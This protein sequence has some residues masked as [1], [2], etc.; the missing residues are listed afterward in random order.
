MRIFLILGGRATSVNGSKI[1]I[2]NFHDSLVNVGCKV[3]LLDTD[4]FA[5]NKGLQPF[6][7]AAKQSLSENLPSIFNSFHHHNKF[8]LVLS[9]LHS[10]QIEPKVFQELKRKNVYIV[11]YTTNFHQFHMY[12]EIAKQ[13]DLNIYIT[14]K[15]KAE[16]DTIGVESYY[17]PL[18]ANP[19]Y[20][21]PSKSKNNN[22][23]FMGSTYGLRPYYI[24]RILQNG[25]NVQVYGP[26]WKVHENFKSFLKYQYDLLNLHLA[27][28]EN[29]VYE[30]NK[31]INR[32]IIFTINKKFKE[33]I[34]SHLSD[35]DYFST[36]SNSKIIINF[37]ESPSDPI[38]INP[39]KIFGCNLRDFETTMSGTFS[40]TQFSDELEDFFCDGKEVVS[41][42]NEQEL[43][44]KLKFYNSHDLL[45]EKI[46]TEGYNRAVKEH[47]WERRFV[48]F[49]N[50]LKNIHL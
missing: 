16:F 30:L 32:R 39:N 8:N 29:A 7:A 38:F 3:T 2:R 21:K 33:Q 25:I 22:V 27:N 34:N 13:V 24:W 42:K 15:A 36:M 47:T 18:A 20:Y 14:K 17:M 11:N 43:I 41:F 19:K 12:K 48:N 28:D 31:L 45:V 50:Y 6:S 23:T 40:L 5:I 10:G 46:A 9:Y 26:G 37:N 35:D 49:F 1:W 44:D 4:Q